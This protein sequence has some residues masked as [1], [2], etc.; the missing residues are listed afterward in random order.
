[1]TTSSDIAKGLL[2]I[3]AMAKRK[4]SPFFEEEVPEAVAK[5]GDQL[6]GYHYSKSQDPMRRLSGE[7]YGT[8]AAGQ[9]MGRLMRDQDLWNRSY[10]YPEGMMQQQGMRTPRPEQSVGSGPTYRVMEADMYNMDANPLGFGGGPSN[11]ER[12]VKEAGFT[13]MYRPSMEM[14]VS[15]RP[16]TEA[17]LLGRSRGEAEQALERADRLPENPFIVTAENIPSTETDFGRWLASQGIDVKERYTDE[18]EQLFDRYRLMKA[19]GVSDY[20]SRPNYGSYMGSINPNTVIQVPDERQA[21]LVADARG[22]LTMQDAVPYYRLEPEG[23]VAGMRITAD[24]SITPEMMQ[25]S[26]GQSGMD[27]T[28]TDLNTMDILNFA[29]DDGVPFSGIKDPQFQQMIADLFEGTR[30]VSNVERFKATSQYNPT[31]ELWK[32]NQGGGLLKAVPDLAGIQEIVNRYNKSFRGQYGFIDPR[33]PMALSA[34]GLGAA[35]I[36]AIMDEINSESKG[37]GNGK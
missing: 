34:A 1:M 8:G 37:E 16:T 4:I 13:G 3:A 30:G 15:Y 29:G 19:L 23:N 22:L 28:R 11:I 21:K 12:Q 14:A 5:Y 10:F 6:T 26:Y 17:S 25:R 7:M 20:T 36:K 32:N 27:F 24:R 31:D 35:T 18:I 2:D 33:I 9:E